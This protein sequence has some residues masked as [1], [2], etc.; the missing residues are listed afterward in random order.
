[1]FKN[2]LLFVFI[3]LGLPGCGQRQTL[4]SLRPLKSGNAHFV[5]VQDGVELRVKR[6]SSIMQLGV[7]QFDLI[8]KSDKTV[9]LNKDDL[10]CHVL[11][12]WDLAKFKVKGPSSYQKGAAL[13]GTLGLVSLASLPFVMYGLGKWSIDVAGAAAGFLIVPLVLLASPFV[14]GY[15]GYTAIKAG[16]ASRQYSQYDFLK[17]HLLVSVELASGESAQRL[18]VGTKRSLNKPFSCKVHKGDV[19]INFDVTL[20]K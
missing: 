18:L 10:S 7:L 17:K 3:L 15:A 9:S 2:K 4:K 8:N 12:K 14:L 1:M 13:G 11:N 5:Q 20:E 16:R 19:V 6:L